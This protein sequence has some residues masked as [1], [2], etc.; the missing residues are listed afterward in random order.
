[1]EMFC[2]AKGWHIVSG[3][4]FMVVRNQSHGKAINNSFNVSM[5]KILV[6]SYGSN[7]QCP[8]FDLKTTIQ[9]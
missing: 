5:C 1:M 8:D 9:L 7:K 6:S 2:A 4:K 3:V